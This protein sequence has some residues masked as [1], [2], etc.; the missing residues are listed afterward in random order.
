M[1]GRVTG[2]ARTQLGPPPETTPQLTKGS[3]H[4]RKLPEPQAQSP[5]SPQP[6]L[7]Q[8]LS[9]EDTCPQALNSREGRETRY[10]KLY[11]TLQTGYRFADG[12]SESLTVS[13]C[14]ASSHPFWRS[15]LLCV[16]TWVSCVMHL[17]YLTL[18]VW[19]IAVKTMLSINY[20]K[21]S[22]RDRAFKSDSV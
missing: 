18:R 13:A 7:V 14:S 1:A 3:A 10:F 17:G 12:L 4:G 8:T 19:R 2:G 21:T 15:W 11:K 6:G 22:H 16:V 5:P 20:N 9:Q